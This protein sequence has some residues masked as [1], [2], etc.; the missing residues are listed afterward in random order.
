MHLV[1][2][3]QVMGAHLSCFGNRPT[4]W[5]EALIKLRDAAKLGPGHDHIFSRLRISYD[6]LES[7]EQHL[8]LDA[9]FFYLGREA[10][11]VKHVWTGCA[12]S[13][14]PMRTCASLCGFSL[15]Y[16]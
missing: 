3:A 5:E 4:L 14:L 8:V 10:D 6:L 11:T 9:A 1:H 2:N 7:S 16:G 15:F 12:K 13:K